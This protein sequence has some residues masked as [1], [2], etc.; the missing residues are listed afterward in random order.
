MHYVKYQQFL[1]ENDILLHEGYEENPIENLEP[2]NFDHHK[3]LKCY[4][5]TSNFG[6]VW[7]PTTY[8][9]KE[10]SLK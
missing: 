10:L 2:Y 7:N 1:V 3:S 9:F 5:A 4:Y 8:M 6:I